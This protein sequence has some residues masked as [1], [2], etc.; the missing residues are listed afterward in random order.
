M[1]SWTR[2]IHVSPASGDACDAYTGPARRDSYVAL[3]HAVQ[4]LATQPAGVAH[5][6]SAGRVLV[7]GHGVQ[8]GRVHA[9]PVRTL[10]T[11]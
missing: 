5:P 10:R 7:V 8:V 2:P 4:L 6:S 11:A 3:G 1:A 9:L